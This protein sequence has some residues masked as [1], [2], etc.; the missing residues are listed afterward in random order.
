MK[1][2]DLQIDERGGA[3][4]KCMKTKGEQHPG[5]EDTHVVAEKRRDEAGT[6]SAEP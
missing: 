2:K 6:L 5:A 4:Q 3:T 1:T